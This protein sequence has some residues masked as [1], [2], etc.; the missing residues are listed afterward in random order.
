MGWWT[1]RRRRRSA[2][3]R[4]LRLAVQLL[5]RRGVLSLMLLLQH[6]IR[7]H[8][9]LC[10][11]LPIFLHRP[12]QSGCPP[13]HLFTHLHH[14]SWCLDTSGWFAAP[15]I[16]GAVSSWHNCILICVLWRD[17]MIFLAA[18]IWY[19][20]L[21][22]SSWINVGRRKYIVFQSRHYYAMLINVSKTIRLL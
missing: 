7:F 1:W 9:Q 13:Q 22:I 4:E 16:P 15:V 11:Y 21:Y 14:L 18:F 5:L 2:S 12:H 3:V 19:R 17:S 20:A 6:R 10:L 8:Y